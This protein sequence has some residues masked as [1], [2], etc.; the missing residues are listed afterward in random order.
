ML[1]KLAEENMQSNDLTKEE[2]KDLMVTDKN[3]SVAAKLTDIDREVV[4]SILEVTGKKITKKVRMRL[5]N[6]Y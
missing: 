1:K 4:V 6:V 2:Y 3:I 5:K